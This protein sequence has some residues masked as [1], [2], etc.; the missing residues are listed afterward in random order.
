MTLRPATAL[1]AREAHDAAL[2]VASAIEAT[3]AAETFFLEA[4]ALAQDVILKHALERYGRHHTQSARVLRDA[5]DGLL[6]SNT[7]QSGMRQRSPE[8]RRVPPASSDFRLIAECEI[9]EELLMRSYERTLLHP[10]PEDLERNLRAVYE[11]C[12]KSRDALGVIRRQW[13]SEPEKGP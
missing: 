8:R 10:L 11:R 2:H 1:T 9:Q 13:R 7:K 5:S 12:R 3:E 6:V 4:A